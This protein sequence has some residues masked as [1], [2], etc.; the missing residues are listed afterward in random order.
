MKKKSI[1]SLKL[2]KEIITVLDQ[3]ANLIKGG[4]LCIHISLAS[5]ARE[6]CD[7]HGN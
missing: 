5:R 7:G 6:L 2:Q 3:K 1:K 4:S